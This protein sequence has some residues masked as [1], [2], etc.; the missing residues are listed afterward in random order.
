MTNI[1]KNKFFISYVYSKNNLIGYGNSFIYTDKF[2]LS[3][4]QI[5]E[6]EQEFKKESLAD[7]LTLIN[8]IKIQND[9]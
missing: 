7:S 4:Y 3:Q 2:L 9:K 6:I 8:Y 1:K 5:R